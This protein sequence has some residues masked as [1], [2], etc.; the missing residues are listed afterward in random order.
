MLIF[1][2]GRIILCPVV[3]FHLC[4]YLNYHGEFNHIVAKKKCL[5]ELLLYVFILNVIHIT[6]LSSVLQQGDF[7]PSPSPPKNKTASCTDWLSAVML[8]L[9]NEL[10]PITIQ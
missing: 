6:D 5:N 9:V 10:I 4:F 2:R 8:L 7:F 3:K 1:V